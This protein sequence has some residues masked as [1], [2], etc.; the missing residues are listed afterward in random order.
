MSSP[1]RAITHQTLDELPTGKTVEHLRSVLVATGT[2]PTRDEQMVRLERWVDADH[3]R[4]RRPRRATPA[5][6]LRR[7]ARAAAPAQRDSTAPTP[8]TTSTSSS[9]STCEPRSPSSIGWP[10]MASRSRTHGQG[11]LDAWLASD[12]AT[13]RRETRHFVRWAKKQKLTTLDAPAIRWGGP[14]GV[15]DTEARWEQARRLLHDDTI[16]PE[17]RVA[18]LLVLLY[19]QWPAAISRLTVDHIHTGDEQVRLRLGDEP[20]VLPEPL[21]ALVLAVVA[22][23]RGHAAVGDPGSLAMAVPRRATRAPDQRLRTHRTTPPTRP[24]TRPEPAPPRCSNS[25]PTCPPPSS[26]A[27]SA[28][29]SPSPSP[30]NAPPPA[31]GP[32]TPPKSAAEHT[33]K[34]RHSDSCNI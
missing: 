3:R 8:P 29:T 19:A 9:D 28:S 32:A 26:P 5:A 31:T 23:R 14:A 2:L 21:A 15:I 10:H 20:V 27:C 16:K 18:G 12:N 17:D 22:T 4:A 33:A 34:E 30:G 1:A 24:P 6:P 13:L 25:P 7:L 11:D